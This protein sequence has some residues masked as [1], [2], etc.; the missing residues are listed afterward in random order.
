MSELIEIIIRI[1][2]ED[3]KLDYDEVM[4]NEKLR[5]RLPSTHP[6]SNNVKKVSNNSSPKTRWQND[7]PEIVKE[8]K[9]ECKK[10]GKKL[11]EAVN[12]CWNTRPSEERE[13]Y[14]NAYENEK[15]SR[16]QEKIKDLEP[17]SPDGKKVLNPKTGNYVSKESPNGKKILK[18][19]S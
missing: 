2:C 10:S 4:K 17:E 6:F 11:S 14:T 8:I 16:L 19:K 1:I 18:M 3:N 7:H 15:E 5:N 12:D 13:K 9:T